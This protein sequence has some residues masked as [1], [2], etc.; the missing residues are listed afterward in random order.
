MNGPSL[1]LRVVYGLIVT[2]LFLVL[3]WDFLVVRF[4]AMPRLSTRATIVLGIVLLVVAGATRLL[5][6]AEEDHLA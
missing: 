1:R 3:V 5:E 6:Q 2:L 4:T